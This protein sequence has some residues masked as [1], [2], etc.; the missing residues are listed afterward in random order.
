[1]IPFNDTKEI[2]KLVILLLVGFPLGA[3]I[4]IKSLQYWWNQYPKVELTDEINN[5]IVDITPYQS[6]A[7]LKLDDGRQLTF[8]G[9]RNYK[10]QPYNLNEF[11]KKGDILTKKANS[12]TIKIY[13]TGSEYIFIHNK[14]LFPELREDL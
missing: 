7:M 11:L 10:L 2:R 14:V 13:R 3:F 8:F 4:M 1:M 6:T 9:S 5:K 12:D